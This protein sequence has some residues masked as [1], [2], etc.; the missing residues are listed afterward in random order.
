[1]QLREY[2]PAFS[3]PPPTLLPYIFCWRTRQANNLVDW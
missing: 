3:L 1:M 2:L